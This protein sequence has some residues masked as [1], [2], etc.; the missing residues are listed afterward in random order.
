[1]LNENL[2]CKI[3]K[4]F[5]YCFLIV[6]VFEYIS[7]S[8]IKN[9][10]TI[11]KRYFYELS[12]KDTI[13]LYALRD[14]SFVG[15]TIKEKTTITNIE[16]V[17]I[18]HASR[19]FI[20]NNN[21]LDIVIRKENERVSMPYFHPSKV[22]SCNI[23][24]HTLHGNIEICYNG[25]AN[26]DKFENVYKITHIQKETDGVSKVLYIDE[27]FTFIG[28]SEIYGSGYDLDKEIRV[29]ET[30]IPLEILKVLI[31]ND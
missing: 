18:E 27:D 14:Y 20:K 29:P 5:I 19:T 24:I 9:T 3:K 8:N 30:N 1:M 16:K 25:K 31:P 13:V 4:T 22:D 15:D 11:N 23:Y 26:F 6:S 17:Y 2:K 7:C 28:M 21:G 12:K 10:E